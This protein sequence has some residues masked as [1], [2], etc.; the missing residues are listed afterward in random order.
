[1]VGLLTAGFL[2]GAGAGP[3]SGVE[4]SPEV[5]MVGLFEAV[6]VEAAGAALL[7]VVFAGE[8]EGAALR[9][10]FAGDGGAAG[11]GLL[12]W[13]EA[14]E[15]NCPDCVSESAIC[16]PEDLRRLSSSVWWECG[17][18][19]VGSWKVTL[20]SCFSI[21]LA[22]E[23]GSMPRRTK[24]ARCVH[25]WATYSNPHTNATPRLR[26]TRRTQK[27]TPRLRLVRREP[28]T[29]HN[30]PHKGKNTLRLVRGKAGLGKGVCTGR[31]GGPVDGLGSHRTPDRLNGGATWGPPWYR[32]LSPLERLG[33]SE[34]TRSRRSLL[35]GASITS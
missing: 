25:D 24:A 8:G 13:L 6:V 20:A 34:G 11:P 27:A 16:A 33:L 18:G 35:C 4:E 2:S 21:L 32:P 15:V 14:P 29:R 17:L 23:P 22:M 30:T 19:L 26:L 3:F 7:G 5:E 12:G 28:S 31:H 10:E 9:V 1:M